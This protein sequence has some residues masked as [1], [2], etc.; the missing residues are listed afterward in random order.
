MCDSRRMLSVASREL[1]NR[2]RDLLIRV[3]AGEEI[4]ITVDGRPVAKL[5][6]IA[7]RPRWVGR[8]RF[9]ARLMDAQADPDLRSELAELV[10]DTTD[11]LP[12]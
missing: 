10:P 11:D 4:A 8:D 5:A 7:S 9:V 6:P 1:R 12:L 3:E 2:T